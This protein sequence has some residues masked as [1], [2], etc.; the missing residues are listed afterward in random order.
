MS[1]V[2]A[3]IIVELERRVALLARQREGAARFTPGRAAFCAELAREIDFG[4]RL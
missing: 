1:D 2:R 4:R 3:R